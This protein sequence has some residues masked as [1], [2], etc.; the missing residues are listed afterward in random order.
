MLEKYFIWGCLAFWAAAAAFLAAIIIYLR[1]K[2]LKKLTRLNILRRQQLF[3]STRFFSSDILD[4]A[5]GKLFFTFSRHAHAALASLIY[6]RTYKATAYLQK[7]NPLSAL[8]LKAHTDNLPPIYRRLTAKRKKLKDSRIILAAAQIAHLLFKEKEVTIFLNK[9]KNRYLPQ[10]LKAVQ[11]YLLST[12]YL[13]EG[14]MLSASEQASL[15]LKLF[16]KQHYYYETAQTY[17]QLAEIYRISC[18]ND[19]AQ[20]MIEAALKIYKD[21]GL[22][23]FYA[24]TTAVFGM[25]MLFENRLEEADEKLAAALHLC[26]ENQLTADILNQIA[27][28][29]LAQKD[30]KNAKK[31]VGKALN[32]HKKQQNKRGEAF[33]SQLLGHFLL[34][35][36]K[37]K[38]ATAHAKKAAALYFEQQNFSAYAESLY[39]QARALCGLQQYEK[40]EKILRQILEEHTKY[41]LNFHIAD[42]YSLLSLIYLQKHDPARAKSLLQQSLHLEQNHNRCTGLAADYANLALIENMLGD[43]NTAALN[44]NIALEYAEKTGDTDLIA[45]IKKK[46]SPK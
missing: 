30:E 31:I 4:W 28:L 19:I 15:A 20:T 32:L 37:L 45:L 5:V 43:T 23:F 40:S 36:G 2:H 44:L 17:L 18:V 10:R 42:A 46:K 6:G 9:L 34:N 11:A 8:L 13:Q 33:S 12:A 39:L 25:L 16:K 41:S 38:Q 22:Q 29:K 35:S 26:P 24:K 3:N 14:D 27:L 7:Q 21:T 1:F